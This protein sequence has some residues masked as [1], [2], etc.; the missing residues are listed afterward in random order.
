MADRVVRSWEEAN[1]KMV[2]SRA[3]LATSLMQQRTTNTRS[4]ISCA[5]KPSLAAHSK[6]HKQ[7][8]P[9][10]KFPG[11]AGQAVYDTERLPIFGPFGIEVGHIDVSFKYDENDNLISIS[12]ITEGD[13]LRWGAVDRS[14]INDDGSLYI[15]SIG[16]GANTSS[17]W[18][19]FNKSAGPGILEELDRSFLNAY[20]RRYQA[21]TAE[22]P[23]LQ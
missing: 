21:E 22:P 20:S 10:T 4:R 3:R 15:L 12:N 18:S 23:P 5:T 9:V 19:W 17:F 7:C 2:Q 11:F 14:I 1:S 13:W 6:M 8:S 16:S